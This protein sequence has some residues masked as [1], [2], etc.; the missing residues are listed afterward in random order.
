MYAVKQ[1]ELAGRAQLDEIVEP[2]GVTALQYT[3]LS[4]LARQSTPITSAA[5]ARLS[6]VRAQSIAHLIGALRRRGL[7][8]RHPDPQNRRRLL[9]TLTAA[10]IGLLDAVEPQIRELE[11]RM[12][13]GMSAAD[14]QRFA[15]LLNRA[16]MNLA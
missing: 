3:A 1:V 6:F 9:I 10:G 4:V 13:S 15:D 14:R 7:V 11:E 8:E 16:R 2:T 5:L 12:L